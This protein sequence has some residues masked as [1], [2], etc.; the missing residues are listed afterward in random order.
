MCSAF[1]AI[2]D[3]SIPSIQSD[4]LITKVDLTLFKLSSD[5]A[6]RLAGV[7]NPFMVTV[8]ILGLLAII[9]SSSAKSK[10]AFKTRPK[11]DEDSSKNDRD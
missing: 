9:S 1:M 11:S 4:G 10:I 2:G 7:G 6:G 5:R 3:N 8:T